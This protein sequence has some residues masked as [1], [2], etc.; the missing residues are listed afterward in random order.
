MTR[1]P[2]KR[3]GPP[4]IGCLLL[5]GLV[6]CS[7]PSGA[8][9][10]SPALKLAT[11]SLTVASPATASPAGRE[12]AFAVLAANIAHY[13]N[14]FEQGQAIIDHTQYANG[15][16]V[17]MAMEDPKSAAARFRDYR[18][19]FTPELDRSFLDAFKEADRN[20]TVHNEPQAVRDWVDDM[21]FMHDDLG[22][23]VHV[24]V[25]YQ[26]SINSQA[27]LDDAAGQVR[28]DLAKAQADARAVRRGVETPS[29]QH[30][31]HPSLPGP[32]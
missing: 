32:A 8:G 14:V 23:W 15:A 2:A 25:D 28:Q 16:E 13:R 6:F 9:T 10:P 27:D 24:A 3:R 19:N 31:Q 29:G 12:D 30:Q 22:R 5:L 26:S 4:V 21:S 18:Q 1:P 17:R 7:H 11:A 20:F